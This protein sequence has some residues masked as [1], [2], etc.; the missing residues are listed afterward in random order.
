MR[1]EYWQHPVELSPAETFV[2]QRIKRAKLFV[3]LRQIHHEL[4]D[5]AFE[6]ELNHIF[7]DSED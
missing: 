1:P 7:Q 2:M 4:F 6:E 5:M 3:F